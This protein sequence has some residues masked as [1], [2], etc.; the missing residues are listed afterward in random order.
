MEFRRV[1]F[2]SIR[3]EQNK[4]MHR[5]AVTVESISKSFDKPVIKPYSDMIEEGQKV[6][7][8]GANGVG[9]TTMMRMLAGDLAPDKGSVKWYDSADMGYMPQD[10]SQ[11][12]QSNKKL[13]DWLGDKY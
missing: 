1:L 13:S 4:V 5:L 7:I 2:R 9:K 12:F 11:Q 10:V 6:A 3:F 8:I